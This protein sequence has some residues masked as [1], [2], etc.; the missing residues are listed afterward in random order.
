MII[1]IIG[2]GN[3][4]TVIGRLLKQNHHTIKVI[5]GRNENDV[6]ALAEN[7]DAQA[8]LDIKTINTESDV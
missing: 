8:C 5:A 3:T 4:A 7:L 2:S 1:S 6:N